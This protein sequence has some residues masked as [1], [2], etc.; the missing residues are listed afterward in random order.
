MHEDVEVVPEHLGQRPPRPQP[1]RRRRRLDLLIIVIV[2]VDEG[3]SLRGESLHLH[4]RA[5]SLGH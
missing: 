4:G 3:C 5:V 2:V 1:L